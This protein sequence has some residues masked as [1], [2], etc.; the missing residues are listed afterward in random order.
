VG[1]FFSVKAA[2]GSSDVYYGNYNGDGQY[3]KTESGTNDEGS[4]IWFKAVTRPYAGLSPVHLTLWKRSMTYAQGDGSDYNLTLR[5]IYDL[6]G[7][8]ESD[9][10]LSL[11]PGG[12]KWDQ[13][14]WDEFEW[15]SNNIPP[16]KRDLHVKAN[17]VQLVFEQIE[18][19]APVTIMQWQVSGSTFGLY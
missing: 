17:H 1:S 5:A 2:D 8:E 14:V 18:A 11:D 19:E 16:R 4:G 7:E 6:S 3:Y 13:V 15:A 9:K 10:A 12:A